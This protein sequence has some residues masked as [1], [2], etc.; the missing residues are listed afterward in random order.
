MWLFAVLQEISSLAEMGCLYELCKVNI[1]VW[2]LS[3][4]PERM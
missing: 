2:K 3:M 4:V 1:T